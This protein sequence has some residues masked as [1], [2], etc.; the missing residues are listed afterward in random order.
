MRKI[1]KWFID[2]P[3]WFKIILPILFLIFMIEIELINNYEPKW[4]NIDGTPD[5]NIKVEM[6]RRTEIDGHI[7]LLIYIDGKFQLEHDPV[8][9][10]EDIL[11][12]L[13][14]I[15]ETDFEGNII[16]IDPD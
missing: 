7:Y 3:L 8:C 5:E 14:Y 1:I 16:W 15:K 9:E 11:E 12:A 4:K 2:S 13:G 10:T 6:I